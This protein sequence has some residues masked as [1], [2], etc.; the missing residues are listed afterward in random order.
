MNTSLNQVDNEALM[1]RLIRYC[2]ENKKQEFQLMIDELHPYDIAQLYK[3][4]PTKHHHKF[5]LLMESKQI[6][7]LLQELDPPMQLD[8]VQ[9][10]GVELSSNIMNLMERDDLADFLNE[11][12]VDKIEELLYAMKKEESQYVQ[13]LMQ[14]EKETAGGL[15]TNQFVWIRSNYTVVEAVEKLRSFAQIAENLYYLYVLDV[16]KKLVGVVSYRDLLLAGIDEK[17]E[18]IMY[19]RVISVPVHMDQEEVARTIERYDFLSVPV[20][21]DDHRLLG[22]ITVDDIIDVVMQEADEDIGRLS[23]T[24][25]TIDFTTGPWTSALRRLPW[26]ILLLLL[27]MIS[28]S[29][30][31]GFEST[32]NQVVA[33]AF[34]MPMIAGMTGNTGTQSLAIVVRGLAAHDLD[35][36]AVFRLIWRELGVGFI[37]GTV[38][39]ILVSGLGFLWEGHTV[40][41]LVVGCSLFMTL[42]IGTMAGT[43]IPLILYKLKIDPAI[44]SGPLITT[45]NDIF[46]LTIYF[47]I[48]SLFI[49]HLL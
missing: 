6:A 42:I 17:V 41:G 35:Q 19:S 1:I 13:N 21:D 16:D 29:I 38:C 30:I 23:A 9:K 37:I 4:L 43:I 8:I 5:L 20:V 26:L 34:F 22:I 27:G 40:L 10:L 49:S 3:E 47:G 11:L 15:M 36:K 46:S 32:L 33:L 7:N 45:L 18:S 12:S 48:A 28:G 39:A 44:A 24:G 25:K 2:K 31:S 14:Y